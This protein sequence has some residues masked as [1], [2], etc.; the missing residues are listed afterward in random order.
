M[1]KTG[2][3][4][5]LL[6]YASAFLMMFASPSATHADPIAAV[7]DID[8]SEA[9][10]YNPDFRGLNNEPERT[11]I[12]MNNPDVVD[13]ALEYGRIGFVRWPGGT[14]TNSFSWKLGF[15]DSEFTGQAQKE[16]R[17]YY[18]QL[19]SKRY[20]IA[21]G[22]EQISD[23]VEFLQ[24]TGAKAVIMVNVLQYNPEQAR[25]LAKYL[26]DNHV[27]VLYFEL[28]NEISFYVP[29]SGNQQA[30]FK[31]GTDYLD[32]AKVFND[33]IKLAYPGAKT[34][35]S[36]SN[37]QVQNFDEDVYNYPNRYWD[38]ITT[39]RFAGNG[40]TASAAMTNANGFLN[41][42]DSLIQNNYVANLG[43]PEIFIGEHGV[44]LGGLLDNT[45]YG[46]IYVSESVLRLVTNPHISY[47]AGYRF[48][49]GVF[50]PSVNH[51]TLLEDAYQ[52]GTAIDTS[53]L[54]F[55]PY[56]STPA[57]SLQVVD[58]AV[59]QGSTAWGTTVTGG[60]D[61]SMTGG[62][63]PALFAQAF[64]GD[65]GKNYVVLTNKSANELEADIRMDG[66]T[67]TAAMTKTYTT[68]ADP[69]ATNS[70]A[71]L[72]VVAVQSSA[73][74]NPVLVPPYSVMRVEWTR[75]ATPETPRAPALMN[76]EVGNQSVTLKWQSSVNATGYKVKYG[77]SSGSYTTTVDAGNALTQ[78]ISGLSNGST[79]YFSVTAYNSGG[80][81]AVSNETSAKLSAPAAPMARRAYAETSGNIAVEWQS[82]PGAAGYKLK[83]GPAPGSY[84]NEID[85]GNNLGK[86]VTG[87]TP[88]TTYYFAVTAYNGRG[89][90]A[91]SAEMT[92]AAAGALPLAPH[93]AAITSESS[94]SIGISWVPTRTE[95]YREF[96]EDGM[97]NSWTAKTG[98]W[99][100]VTDNARGASFY[101]SSLSG[102][103]L[104]IFDSSATGSYEG[105]AMFEPVAADAGKAAYAYGVVARY[106]D[107][108]NYYKFVYNVN[109]DKFK[110]V[111]VLNGTETVIASKTRAQ[112][113]NGANAAALDL[114]HLLLHIR[115]D[116]STI[117][118]SVNQFG[119]I[120]TV[121]DTAHPTG[122]FGLYTLNERTNV[123]WTRIYRNNADSYTVYRST[124]PNT[125]FAVLQSGITGTSYTDSTAAAGTTYYY[126]VTAENGN[127]SSY[128]HSNT[129]RKN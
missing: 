117:E 27:P 45:Q 100:V 48:A 104:T 35:I 80:E 122:K 68:S 49:N 59:N 41:G 22:G 98:T 32:R 55:V 18:N 5:V 29:D 62:T 69:L 19:Y 13:A 44:Q 28:G 76:T 30:A 33:A 39:H 88:G 79:Y 125:N 16:P 57:A 9:I 121:T 21:K 95:T 1:R 43:D 85:V 67:V 110:I 81:S 63:M 72:T 91:A 93:D 17:R 103:G 71:S 50:T 65:N 120:L 38:A 73:T 106:V 77:T 42:W 97:A 102:T 94:T 90:G 11:P 101:Q 4:A 31:T 25:D 58:G 124:Q 2:I 64:K 56:Y 109:E 119:P 123:N 10:S 111:K 78:T 14:P 86:L 107:N 128:H 54:D 34:V 115:V 75:S 112:V 52:D 66:S 84:P 37:G 53:A 126:R 82:V 113:L 46:G 108:S 70:A 51:G 60:G 99:S 15:T 127:G 129:L 114:S 92:A 118:G 87:L 8:T 7:I 20:Q 3:W 83:Y 36:M 96:F 105:E 47:L 12:V 23:Y 24:R 74:G 116:G 89:E 6:V 40:T 61:V 26:Y